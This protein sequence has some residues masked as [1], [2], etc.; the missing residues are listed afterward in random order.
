MQSQVTEFLTQVD[1][2][3]HIKC[4]RIS[5]SVV[6]GF[7]VTSSI[8]TAGRLIVNNC[9]PSLG[10]KSTTKEAKCHVSSNIQLL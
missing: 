3:E 10:W 4:A 1:K 8:F 9:Q 5:S 6:K 2:E 7:I